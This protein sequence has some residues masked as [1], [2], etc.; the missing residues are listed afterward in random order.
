[1]RALKQDRIS[2]VVGA[3]VL[4]VLPTAARGQTDIGAAD[5][6][7]R[8]A[9][10]QPEGQHDFDFE[11]GTWTAHLR[12]RLHPLTGSNTWVD[13][14]GTS[15]VRKVWDGRANLGE[16]EVGD[17]TGHVEGL[18]LRLYNPQSHQWSIYW[19]NSAD[20]S[21]GTAMIGQFKDGRGEFY[22]QE[23]FQ[24]KSIY[25]RFIFSGI[26]PT[27]F[28]IEQAF[29]ADGGRTW[30]TNWITTFTRPAQGAG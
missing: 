3:L 21:L 13:L 6:T 15:T 26:T 25:V 4:L 1:V 5:A 11:F 30:E 23:I 12:R 27:S 14:E 18:S 8:R 29:S 28:R 10:E 9:A 16:L 19:S 24:G 17:A 20:G 22:D 2:F 7:T